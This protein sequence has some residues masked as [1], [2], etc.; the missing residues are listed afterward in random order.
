MEDNMFARVTIGQSKPEQIEAIIRNFQEQVGP[1]S[2]KMTGFKGSYF[3]VNRKNGKILGIAL[4]D[5]EKDLQA[6]SE[7]VKHLS[8]GVSQGAGVTKPLEVEIYEV[9]AQ[10]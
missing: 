1:V 9:A 10:L 7:A 5:S 4:W 8:A 3:L 6:G 2:K